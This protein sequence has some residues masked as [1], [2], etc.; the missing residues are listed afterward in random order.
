MQ[1]SPSHRD[2]NGKRLRIKGY[3]DKLASKALMGELE[4]ALARGEQGLVD[5]FKDAKAK[6]LLEHVND[7]IADLR[8]LGA[9]ASTS[10]L[11]SHG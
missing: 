1:P 11:V 4:K 3:T 2:A 5:P 9:M 8:S 6:P 10:P 7:W